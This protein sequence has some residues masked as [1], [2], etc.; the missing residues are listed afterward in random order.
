LLEVA[1]HVY[2]D[3]VRLLVVQFDLHLLSDRPAS[4]DNDLRQWPV[5]VLDRSDAAAAFRQD[6]NE[7]EKKGQ[8]ETFLAKHL[9]IPNDDS[10]AI[11]LTSSFLP[12]YCDPWMRGY[13]EPVR[14]QTLHPWNVSISEAREIQDR[15]AS[16]IIKEGA[17][18]DVRLVAAADV[19]I[20][21][22][23]KLARAAVVVLS[24]PEMEVVERQVVESEP[25]FPYVPGLLTFREA[26]L[27]LDA[28]QQIQS[29]PDLLLI[30]GQ[31]YAHPRRFG[32]ACHLGLL[33]DLPTI[34]C[35]KSRLCGEYVEP[36]ET[37]ASSQP[38][39]SDGEVIGSVV[40]TR[41]AVSP[42]FVSV[43]HRIGLD[44]AVKWTL[45]CCRGHRLPEPSR[46]AHMAAGEHLDSWL[47]GRQRGQK[48]VRLAL[49]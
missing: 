8:Q 3:V 25:S 37:Q 21:R 15:L 49:R 32:I 48:T 9:R 28:F 5:G 33:L 24:Y 4:G 36:A 10:T 7:Q 40:R 14:I 2:C 22:E 47:A 13:N 29:Q 11:A 45:A 35:A 38:L 27:L 18:K 26:P 42:V 31:G 6:G 23:E 20:H 41:A 46:F 43:G 39:L 1:L 12:S 30:D 44:E 34:G 19:S 16:R 17:P